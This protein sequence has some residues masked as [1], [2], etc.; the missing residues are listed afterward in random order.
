VKPN[1]RPLGDVIREIMKKYRLEDHLEETNLVEN[2]SKICGSMIASH[3]SGLRFKDHVLF[4]KVDS[5]ALRQELQYM[6]E[7]LLE[8]LNRSAGRDLIRDIV[9]R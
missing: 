5:A 9:L 7:E 1:D 6:K 2:W 3:T 8:K 4:V